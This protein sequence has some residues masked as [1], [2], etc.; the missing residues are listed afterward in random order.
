MG[1]AFTE[2]KHRVST[3]YNSRDGHSINTGYLYE[4][5][6]KL[7]FGAEHIYRFLTRETDTI[8]GFK[9]RF[10]SGEVKCNISTSARAT[11][12]ISHIIDTMIMLRAYGQVD[13]WRDV[14]PVFGISF[15]LGSLSL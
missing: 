13:F 7:A 8:L 12:E 2:G 1:V 15:D 5:N 6:S 11:S 10:A 14:P 9:A 3:S 4:Y